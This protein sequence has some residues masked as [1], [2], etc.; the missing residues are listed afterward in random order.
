[1][2][3]WGDNPTQC[4]GSALR[5][6]NCEEQRFRARLPEIKARLFPFQ[7]LWPW[8]SYLTFL[9][10]S[11]QI[12]KCRCLCKNLKLNIYSVCK[13]YLS[14][15]GGQVTKMS[16]RIPGNSSAY[17]RETASCILQRPGKW[18]C[19]SYSQGNYY[20]QQ[21]QKDIS[22]T[23][24]IGNGKRI[25]GLRMQV[26]LKF[27]EIVEKGALRKMRIPAKPTN[28]G[29]SHPFILCG[30][31]SWACSQAAGGTLRNLSNNRIWGESSTRPLL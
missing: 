11:F 18:K 16:R 6:Q 22:E 8:G 24:K 20:V 30:Y 4:K 10:L 26:T 2:S 25:F 15:G 17:S 1:M 12:L 14:F 23:Q 13:C 21:W 28:G 9:G 7:D 19:P 5:G 29:Q 27:S 31:K 3:N